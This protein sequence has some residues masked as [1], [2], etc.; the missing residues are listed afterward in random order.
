MATESATAKRRAEAETAINNHV[1]AL[2]DKFEVKLQTNN[3]PVRDLEM[4]RVFQLESLAATLQQIVAAASNPEPITREYLN[5]IKTKAALVA[6]AE[7][8]NIK[9]VPDEMTMEQIRATILE[10]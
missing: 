3:F 8:S 2:A 7:R 1:S 6:I 10:G 9:V 4:K 5:T